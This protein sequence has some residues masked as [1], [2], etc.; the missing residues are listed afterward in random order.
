MKFQGLGIAALFFSLPLS[1][2]GPDLTEGANTYQCYGEN[3]ECTARDLFT[4]EC[5]GGVGPVPCAPRVCADDTA[6]AVNVAGRVCAYSVSSCSLVEADSCR[7][8]AGAS[9]IADG[10]VE[11][12]M[13]TTPTHNIEATVNPAMSW[14][15]VDWD[16]TSA[17]ATIDPVSSISLHDDAGDGNTGRIVVT[18]M[19]TWGN[20]TTLGGYSVQ[21]PTVVNAQH[22]EGAK[23]STGEFWLR[24]NTVLFA[25]WATIDGHHTS[26][27]GHPLTTVSGSIDYAAGEITIDG[28]IQGSSEEGPVPLTASFHLVYEF[29]PEPAPSAIVEVVFGQNYASIS[30][31]LEP[32]GPIAEVTWYAGD[33]LRTAGFLD[34]QA[35]IGHNSWVDASQVTDNAVSLYLRDQSGAASIQVVCLSENESDCLPECPPE[36]QD[37]Y[38]EDE[39]PSCAGE[40]GGASPGGCWCDAACVSYGDC[41]DDYAPQCNADSCWGSCDTRAPG[42]CWCDAAC[43]SF[44]DC[45]ADKVPVCGE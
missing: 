8:G 12:V 39:P 38:A 23:I 6:E 30:E 42:G 18:N 26:V 20:D 36:N 4:G 45:C 14:I 32:N 28:S 3:L 2:C 1:A 29:E 40:C 19:E 22:F 5:I 7:L 10:L 25:N 13:A 35:A 11:N 15:T 21:E 31:Y 37:C 41:C 34:P 24:T 16:G 44:G 33:V 27:M 9:S 17:S 43:T